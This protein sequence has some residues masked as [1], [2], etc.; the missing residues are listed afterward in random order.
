M[1]HGLLEKFAHLGSLLA[2]GHGV[3]EIFIEREKWNGRG[4]YLFAKEEWN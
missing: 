4:F 2:R 3:G 1:G